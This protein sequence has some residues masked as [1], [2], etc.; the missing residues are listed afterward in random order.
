MFVRNPGP[1]TVGLVAAG[2]ICLCSPSGAVNLGNSWPKIVA[3][4]ENVNE[5][6][7]LHNDAVLLKLFVGIA[8]HP[9]PLA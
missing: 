8:Y 9:Y 4:Y 2:G 3:D 7:I 5:P 6:M 1:A